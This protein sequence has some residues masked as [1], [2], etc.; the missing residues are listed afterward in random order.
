MPAAAACRRRQRQ[1]HSSP[2]MESYG[3]ELTSPPLPLV[4]LIGPPELLPPLADYLRTQHAPRLQSLGVPDAH[5]AAGAFGEPLALCCWCCALWIMLFTCVDVWAWHAGMP[6]CVRV[7]WHSSAAVLRGRSSAGACLQALERA[8]L[9]R[10]SLEAL[11][12]KPQLLCLHPLLQ[13]L[14]R[15]RRPA[16]RPPAF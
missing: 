10:A 1:S 4:A 16:D 5:S 11:Y 9:H 13:A 3:A 2:A 6:G 7:W 15:R 12:T 8:P 14:A